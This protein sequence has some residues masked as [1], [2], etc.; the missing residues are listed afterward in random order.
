[1]NRNGRNAQTNLKLNL[2]ASG[3]LH[4]SAP[5]VALRPAHLRRCIHVPVPQA[6]VAA[7]NLVK[8]PIVQLHRNTGSMACNGLVNHGNS[9]WCGMGTCSCSDQMCVDS[10]Q[11]LILYKAE[12]FLKF[13]QFVESASMFM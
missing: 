10:A 13:K 3:D 1:M 11:V 5:G 8:L 7:H 2:L 4:I 9:L 12:D 6:R